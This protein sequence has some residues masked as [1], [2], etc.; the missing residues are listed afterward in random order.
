MVKSSSIV[1]PLTSCSLS[2]KVPIQDQIYPLHVV[3]F[4]RT[5]FCKPGINV[6]TT[7]AK[8]DSGE[9]VLESFL[10]QIFMGVLCLGEPVPP[11]VLY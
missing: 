4:C 8:T 5:S 9:R 10:S 3:D 1:V 7:N 2:N 11:T 6:R